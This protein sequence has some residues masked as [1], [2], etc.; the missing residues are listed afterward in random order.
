MPNTVKTRV[1]LDFGGYQHP[2]ECKWESNVMVSESAVGVVEID[3]RDV[4]SVPADAVFE[5]P[6][7]C[8]VV[9]RYDELD[10]SGCKLTAEPSFEETYGYIEPFNG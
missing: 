9:Y 6:H 7:G 5:C 1:K 4:L 8:G 3:S 10:K 2:G